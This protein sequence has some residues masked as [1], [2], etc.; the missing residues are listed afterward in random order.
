MNITIGNAG[1]STLTNFPAYIN[2]T[3]DSDMQ[4]DYIDL[5]FYNASCGN[6]GSLMDYEIESYTGTN[7]HIW[8]RIPS[9]P[10]AGTVISV[11]YMNDTAVSSGENAAGVWEIKK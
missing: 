6:D 3:Y 1:T 11:Y 9:L 5:R 10:T 7:A 2:L 8:T 4:S